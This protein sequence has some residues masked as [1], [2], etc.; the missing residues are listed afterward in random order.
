MA[1]YSNKDI[2]ILAIETSTDVCSVALSKNGETSDFDI[3]TEPRM[4]TSRLAPMA[5]DLLRRNGLSARD[6]SAVAVSSGPGSYTGLRVG[7]SMA[8]GLCFGASIPLIAVNT[9]DLLAAQGLSMYKAVYGGKPVDSVVPMIDAR[10]ME[11]YQAEY[12]SDGNRVSEVEP[13][14]LETFSYS[15]LIAKNRVLF[16]G[17]GCKKFEGIAPKG[18]TF[19]IECCPEAQYMAQ[20]AFKKF[21]AKNFEDVAYMEPFY[22]KEFSIGVNKKKILG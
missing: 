14:I 3:V 20:L 4:Q 2:L 21:I 18:D 15:G 19:F 13:K 10:R 16:C 22:L 11:V 17:N 5:D 9:L 7:V 1:M 8:K 6:C 12:D